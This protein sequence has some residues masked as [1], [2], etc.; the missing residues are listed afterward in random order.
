MSA[1]SN[2][3]GSA[4]VDQSQNFIE[5][6]WR[7][8]QHQRMPVTGSRLARDDER[9]KMLAVQQM[10]DRP[11]QALDLP[12]PPPDRADSLQQYT[13]TLARKLGS[14]TDVKPADVSNAIN[15]PHMLSK[16]AARIAGEALETASRQP[17]LKPVIVKDRTGRLMTEFVGQSGVKTRGGWMTRYTAPPMVG[18]NTDTGMPDGST[19]LAVAGQTLRY[20]PARG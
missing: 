20:I 14:Y 5:A 17:E 12:M 15:D 2:G 19:G 10:F 11:F 6:R 7:S 8:L 9:G 18:G 3:H 13:A 1:G 16:V 4:E